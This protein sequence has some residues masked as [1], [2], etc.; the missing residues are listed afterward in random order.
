MKRTRTDDGEPDLIADLAAALAENHPLPFLVLASTLL[1]VIDPR[2]RSPFGRASDS[3]SLSRD[4][5]VGSL[6]AVDLPET[7]ALLTVIGELTDDQMLQR[8]IRRELAAR[9]H[10]LPGWLAELPHAE[11]AQRA[12]EV[13]HVLGDGDNV[14]IGTVLADGSEF[15]AVIYIDHNMGTLVKDAF[16]VPLSVD[17]VVGEVLAAAGDADVEARDLDPADARVR[18]TDAIEMSAITFPPIETDTWP[19]CRPLVE[20]AAGLLPAGGSGYQRP[21]WDDAATSALARRFLTSAFGAGYDDDEHQSLLDSL[22]WFGTDYGPGD[23]LR[24]SSVA[25]EI[26]LLDWIPRKIVADVPFLDKAP[27]LLRAFIRFCHDERG[28]RPELTDETLAAVDEHEREYRRLIRS[29][30]PQGPEALLAAMGVPG[31]DGPAAG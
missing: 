19:S 1:T 2:Q 22:L 25:V 3:E 12:V 8:R 17:E 13:V 24:W 5:L 11:P 21:D 4:E 30:R 28:I 23:P 9:S 7:T 10:V 6:L 15:T 31:A 14:L 26:L 20:W 29:P 27:D 16:V 18:V